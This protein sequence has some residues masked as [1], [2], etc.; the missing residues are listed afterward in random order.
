VPK[1]PSTHDVPAALTFDEKGLIVAVAQ[2]HLTG[3]LRM[4]GWMN[5]EAL[6]ATLRTGLATFYSR[7]RHTLWTKGE[8][9]GHTLSVREVLADCDGDTLILR[10]APKGP[11][12]HT[13]RPNCFFS[14]LDEEGNPRGEAKAQPFLE[15]LEATLALRRSSTADRSYTRSLLD[16]GAGKITAKLLEESRE[17]GQ[18]LEGEPRERVVSEAADVLYHLL[19]GLCLREV[20]LRDVLAELELRTAQS[21]HAEK[22]GRSAK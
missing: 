20:P 9:S 15:E 1:V 4:V 3:E 5:R 17:L 7:S 6:A 16:A 22:A 2:D 13:G 10:V 19:V 18:A 14:T 12:C 21:G 8:T 11:T